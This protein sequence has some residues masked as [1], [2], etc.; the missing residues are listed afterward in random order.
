MFVDSCFGGWAGQMTD[1]RTAL[2]KATE[3]P[4]L[5]EGTWTKLE[6]YVCGVLGKV[7]GKHRR[8]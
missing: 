2:S 1:R 4:D 8:G 3:E 6:S 5:L 7:L